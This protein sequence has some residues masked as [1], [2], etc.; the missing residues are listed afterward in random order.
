MTLDAKD[1]A[2]DVVPVVGE[3]SAGK[4]RRDSKPQ[5]TYTEDEVEVKFSQQ[6]SVL[7][8]KI[9]EQD[10]QLKSYA[11]R[12]AEYVAFKAEQAA[13][14]KK[15]DEEEEEAV[16]DDRPAYDALLE[17][18]KKKA[19]DEAKVT[20][21]TERVAKVTKRETEL[22]AVIERDKIL[23]RTQLAAE[24]AVEKGVSID[25]ILKLAKEDT[26]EAYEAVAE[27]LPKVKEL[28]EIIADSSRMGGGG[29]DFG[30]MSAEEKVKFGMEHPNVKMI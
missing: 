6:R 30:K 15:Q 12:E 23:T 22:A 19:E 29:T 21:L 26:R 13:W 5:K 10:K 3:D 25:A 20:E 18:R 4:S 1:K 8:K 9:A 17:R 14:Q 2:K 11:G 27:V 28:P 24:V 16:R 7:D